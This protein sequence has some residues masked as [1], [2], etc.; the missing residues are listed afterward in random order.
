MSP[1]LYFAGTSGNRQ[2]LWDVK[3]E[4]GEAPPP[5][6]SQA[7]IAFKPTRENV[8]TSLAA[9]WVPRGFAVVYRTRLARASPR[10]ASPSALIRSSSRRRR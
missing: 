8:S 6:T 7:A 2:F 3:Q 5:R 4:V 10:A 9:T 1:R